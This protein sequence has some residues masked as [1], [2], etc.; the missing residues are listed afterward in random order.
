MMN[1]SIVAFALAVTLA[2]VCRAQEP[3]EP[4]MAEPIPAEA[5]PPDAP[6]PTVP[7]DAVG[8]TEDPMAEPPGRLASSQPGPGVGVGRVHARFV[9][10]EYRLAGLELDHV[11]GAA[12]PFPSAR[13]GNRRIDYELRLTSARI[14]LAYGV[15]AGGLE[16][17]M[18]GGLG[19][20]W[21]ELSVDAQNNSAVNNGADT[22]LTVRTDDADFDLSFGMDVW[23]HISEDV[24]MG[25][26]MQLLYAHAEM[27][28]QLLFNPADIS[29]D[30]AVADFT[31]LRVGV[32]V[33]PYATVWA[34]VGLVVVGS[35]LEVHEKGGGHWSSDLGT[36]DTFFKGL[37]GAS[38]HPGENLTANIELGLM[39]EVQMR[40]A[41]G[42]SF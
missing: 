12:R 42:W 22:E 32:D 11:R 35:S 37:L 30:T 19:F 9:W 24:V 31:L 26:G 23:T 1:K 4:P 8:P 40:I 28:D 27:D 6:P 36:D 16:L 13:V 10:Q 21:T 14:E 20:G 17:D 7:P 39:P 2:G 38:L 18:F 15:D 33:N 25:F 5:P 34:G 3:D 29:V 41:I